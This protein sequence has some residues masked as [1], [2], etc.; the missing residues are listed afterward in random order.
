MKKGFMLFTLLTAVVAG[1]AHADDDAI[2]QTLSKLGV[3][4]ATVQPSPV[5]GMKTVLSDSG[6][7]YV[8]EDGK[9]IIQGPMY[10]VSGG[11]PVN[12]TN[13]LLV[14]QLNA[15]EKEMIVY[16][17]AQ[18]K[19]VI[20]VFT[21]TTCG[22]CH[23]LHEEMKDYN[24]LGITVRYLAFPRQGLESQAE[25]DMKSIWCAQDRNK[26]F[27]DAMAGKAVKAATCNVDIARHYALGVQ[28]GINGTP[29]I[30]L[31]NG[32]VVPGYQGPKEMKA[33]L[34]E[35]QKQTGGK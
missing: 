6:V 11:H 4:G 33:F 8:T 13:R 29:A 35:H 1:M 24:A 27:N 3:Q 16:K 34:D 15:L 2:R 10:D 14:T 26:A 7:L 19:H 25:Q 32:Y 31:N 17:A 20:T 9:H 5:T 28:F 30:V 18:E 22:Y 12:V 23:K 21:D